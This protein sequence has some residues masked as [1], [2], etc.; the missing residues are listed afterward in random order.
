TR[1]NASGDRVGVVAQR[2]AN[3]H[4]RLAGAQRVGVAQRHDGGHLGV[5]LDDRQVG[6]RVGADELAGYRRAVSE[7]HAQ[8]VAALDDVV[9]GDDVA[10]FADDE[11][12]ARAGR[13]NLIGIAEEAAGEALL[14]DDR[15]YSRADL[16]EDVGRSR[17]GT[18]VAWRRRLVLRRLIARLGDRLGLVGGVRGG[19]RRGRRG[20]LSG[21]GGGGDGSAP[22]VISLVE[23]IADH[24]ADDP[25]ADHP[26]EQDDDGD[27]RGQATADSTIAVAAVIAASRRWFARR[28]WI[29]IIGA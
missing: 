18:L 7:D 19:R 3:R 11:A 23:R 4:D 28:L 2:A 8:L 12:G 26:E 6:A 24:A 13:H 10:V 20:L 21:R 25:A 1:D 9:V 16:L 27:Q 17:I 22:V 15:H 29:L 14:V 5:D